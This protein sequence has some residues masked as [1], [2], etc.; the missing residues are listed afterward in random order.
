M[1]NVSGNLTED[2]PD[3]IFTF[4]IMIVIFSGHCFCGLFLVFSADHE[5]SER[6]VP[7]GAVR[8][9]TIVYR[10]TVGYAKI[11]LLTLLHKVTP[12]CKT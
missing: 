2:I 4:A 11:S 3:S 1:K 6:C 12:F 9:P 8:A 10:L 5:P 7:L